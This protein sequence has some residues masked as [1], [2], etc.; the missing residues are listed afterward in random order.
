MYQVE[1]NP[2]AFWDRDWR[3]VRYMMGR[4]HVMFTGF[5]NM[6]RF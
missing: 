6:V 5:D 2:R 3:Q 1:K 4:V